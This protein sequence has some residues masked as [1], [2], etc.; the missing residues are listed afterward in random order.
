MKISAP[1]HP[2][3]TAVLERFFEFFFQAFAHKDSAHR[4]PAIDRYILYISEGQKVTEQV[5]TQS[6]GI[7]SG[8]LSAAQVPCKRDSLVSYALL[9]N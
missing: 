3:F 9:P 1:R 2:L 6:L 8:G 4:L 5:D 7:K